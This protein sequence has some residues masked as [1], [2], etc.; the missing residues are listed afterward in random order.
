MSASLS[1]W[2]GG[3]EGNAARAAYVDSCHRHCGCSTGITD[4]EYG[5]NPKQA[6]AQWYRSLW[7]HVEQERTQLWFQGGARQS[8]PCDD[9][10]TG[11]CPAYTDPT[12]GTPPPGPAP[13]APPPPETG[14]PLPPPP[15]PP[16]FASAGCDDDCSE[17]CPCSWP[18]RWP[19]PACND[20]PWLLKLLW[21]VQAVVVVALVGGLVVCA[22]VAVCVRKAA[23]RG[24]GAADSSIYQ[25]QPAASETERPLEQQS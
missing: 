9:C 25:E 1:S 24:G 22:G 20:S 16:P 21:V 19:D 14:R 2:L 6:F 7:A 8:F 15:P 11:E 18:R 13:R 10:C 3:E 23:K 12:A 4:I 17:C 5:L